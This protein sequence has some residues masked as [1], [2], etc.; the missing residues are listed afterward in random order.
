MMTFFVCLQIVFEFLI[1]QKLELYCLDSQENKKK[2]RN[3][4]CDGQM[5]GE[6]GEKHNTEQSLLFLFS[7]SSKEKQKK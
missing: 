4:N 3:K 7:F 6:G 2:K 5:C 1:D